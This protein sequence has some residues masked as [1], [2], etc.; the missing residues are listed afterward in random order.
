MQKIWGCGVR[1][2]WA[3]QTSVAHSSS[4]LEAGGSRL[5]KPMLALHTRQSCCIVGN[6]GSRRWQGSRMCELWKT[7]SLILLHRYRFFFRN[8]PACVRQFYR[9]AMLNALLM[10]SN[11]TI[12]WFEGMIYRSVCVCFSGYTQEE[13]VEIAHRHL[14]PNQLEQHGLT[15]QQLHIPQDTTQDIISRYT[16]NLLNLLL[17]SFFNL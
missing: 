13:R 16:Q 2:K 14:I 7:I 9:G 12:Y 11:S 17:I 6:V 1:K 4:L 3:C 10:L 8:C 5:H 15:P